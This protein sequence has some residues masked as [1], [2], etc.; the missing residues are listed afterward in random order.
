VIQRV[1]R[2][3]KKVYVRL[4]KDQI[5]SAPGFDEKTYMSKEYRDQIGTY[6]GTMA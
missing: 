6:Y 3:S 4:T 5:S 1:D 2:D